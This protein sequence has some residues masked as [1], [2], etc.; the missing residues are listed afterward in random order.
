[1]MKKNNTLKKLAK[2]CSFVV[3]FWFAHNNS[4]AQCTSLGVRPDD[5]F[6]VETWNP[7]CNGGSDGY[8]NITNIKSSSSS[9]PSANRPYSIRILTGVGGGIHP[10]YPTPFPIGNST[11]FVVPNMSAGSFAIDIIDACGNTSADKAITMGQPANPE[12]Y[13]D[14]TTILKRVTSSGGTCGDTF[15]VKTQFWRY[16]TGQTLSVTFTNSANQTYTPVN[17]ALTI[18][19]TA[20]NPIYI[21]NITTEVPVAFFLGGTITA[22]L[23]S[24]Q[25]N[26]PA[27]KIS[28]S[29]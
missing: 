18:P 3:L 10:S 27:S 15:V 5:N 23:S 22:N 4:Y 28:T 29:S 11:S 16:E 12:F 25:C 7:T 24:N 20:A 2:L 13:I 1:M 8:L 26:R 21:S 17:N 9:L 19:R 14:Y 6:Q